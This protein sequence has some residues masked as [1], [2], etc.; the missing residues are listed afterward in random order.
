LAV[1]KFA[2]DHRWVPP[3]ASD[4]LD[5]DLAPAEV[6]RVQRHVEQCPQC[7]ELLQGLEEI[8]TALG[9]LRDDRDARVAGRVV[10]SL[11]ISLGANPP[12]GG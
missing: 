6:A 2:R 4:Y 5:G 1:S 3:R 12:T 7:R 8:V 11:K 9:T 10:A